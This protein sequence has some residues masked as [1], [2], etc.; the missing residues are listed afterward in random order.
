VRV[1]VNGVVN[2]AECAGDIKIYKCVDR[3][4]DRAPWAVCSQSRPQ[5]VVEGRQGQTEA[6][7]KRAEQTKV[8]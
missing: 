6:E 8:D 2:M 3:L 4:G 7:D 5:V 1:V